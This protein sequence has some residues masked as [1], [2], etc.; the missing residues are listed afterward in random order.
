MADNA[1]GPRIAAVRIDPGPGQESV[2]DYPRPPRLEHSSRHVIVQF[3]GL[4]VAETRSAL[5]VCETSGPPVYYLSPADVLLE[6]LSPVPGTTVCEWKGA[7]SYFDLV[8]GGRRSERAAWTYAN[9]H[10]PYTDLRDCI[11]FYP[12]CVDG[13]FLDD[14]RVQAQPGDYYGGWITREI[15]GPFKGGPG[16]LHW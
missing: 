14:E 6:L 2:W 3:A 15:V 13:C 12:G 4:T 11:A 16:T 8:A 9:P 1:P 5:R 10:P 7:A